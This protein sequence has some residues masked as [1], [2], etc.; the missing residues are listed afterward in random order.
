M[1]GQGIEQPEIFIIQEMLSYLSLVIPSIPP[2]S[3]QGVFG[4]ETEKAVIAFQNMVGLEPTGI[5]NEV[6]W[7]ELYRIYREQRFMNYYR[8]EPL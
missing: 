4:E 1:K 8:T 7:N 2:I 6:T 3:E 5:V